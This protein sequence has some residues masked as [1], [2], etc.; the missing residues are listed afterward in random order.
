M[1]ITGFL[2]FSA[3]AVCLALPSVLADAPTVPASP[4]TP[5][6][7]VTA[8][9]NPQAHGPVV[10]R[11]AM[12]AQIMRSL[13]LTAEQRMQAKAIRERTTAAITAIKADATLTPDQQQVDIEATRVAGHRQ[14]RELLTD[15]QREKLFRLQRQLIKFQRLLRP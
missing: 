8:T 6:S 7:V 5:P 14:F 15:Q 4:A 9:A 10:F 3:V 13:H 1:K 12:Q 11:Q 2:I